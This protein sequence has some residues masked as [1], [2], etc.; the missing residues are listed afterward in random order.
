MQRDRILIDRIDQFLRETGMSAT[1]F[2]R[3]TTRNPRLVLDLRAGQTPGVL[4][5]KNIVHFMNKR[6][7][8][9]KITAPNTQHRNRQQQTGTAQ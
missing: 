2:G 6:Q 5:R 1:R 7:P 8:S 3:A 9:A 4:M